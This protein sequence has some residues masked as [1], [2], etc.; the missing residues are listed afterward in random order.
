MNEKRT[1]KKRL[2]GLFALTLAMVMMMGITASAAGQTY[3]VA[4]PS[5][6]AGFEY[7]SWAYTLCSDSACTTKANPYP[8][9]LSDGDVIQT[10]TGCGY[11]KISVDNNLVKTL[12]YDSGDNQ[13]VIPA[14]V[15]YNIDSLVWDSNSDREGIL[16]LSTPVAGQSG[17]KEEK[18]CTH[19]GKYSKIIK[20]PTETE[21]GIVGWYCKL[22]HEKLY[23]EYMSSYAYFLESTI[24]KIE[25]AE[26][27]S[28]LEISSKIW[29]TLSQDVMLAL[30]ARR[31]LNVVMT[32]RYQH[33]DYCYS[34]PTGATIDTA[35]EY[36]GPMYLGR[37][38]GM[39]KLEK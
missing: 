21:D 5:R 8:S 18:D 22:C 30:A 35:D 33:E 27:G 7:G 4:T 14:G 17:A 37:L 23:E 16:S 28:T 15:T 36:Y 6:E 25:N 26:Q 20:Q 10:V 13:F 24:E 2:T 1:F 11:L 3:Y 34:I 9:T 39:T 19:G 31:D 12:D 29:N 38:Y 32:F